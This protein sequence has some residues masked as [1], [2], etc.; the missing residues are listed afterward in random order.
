M[1][2]CFSLA[3]ILSLRSSNGTAGLATRE[4]SSKKISVSLKGMAYRNVG[5]RSFLALSSGRS[6]RWSSLQSM[7]SILS[8]SK[9]WE[10]TVTRTP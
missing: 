1:P 9:G 8:T 5:V 2:R 6:R 4:V 3:S 10:S 7:K